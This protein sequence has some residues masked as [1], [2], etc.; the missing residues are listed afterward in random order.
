MTCETTTGADSTVYVSAYRGDDINL[1][2]ALFGADEQPLDIT[3]WTW[4]AQLRDSAGGLVADWTVLVTDA[5]A[6]ELSLTLASATTT[7]LAL[8]DYDWDLQATDA[9]GGVKTL[10]VGRLRI[11]EDQTR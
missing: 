3:G 4:A 6:G 7:G 11:K 10:I 1:D 8:A 5:A 2:V 9:V